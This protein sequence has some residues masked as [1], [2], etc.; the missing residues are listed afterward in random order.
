MS[1]YFPD[2]PFDAYE[3]ERCYHRDCNGYSPDPPR[4]QVRA[5]APDY[6]PSYP[7]FE[8]ATR[9]L[10]ERIR[11]THRIES[12]TIGSLT[13]TERPVMRLVRLPDQ[14]REPESAPIRP[15][16]PPRNAHF[17]PRLA[18]IEARRQIDLALAMYEVD[19]TAYEWR[20]L[21]PYVETARRS[22]KAFERAAKPK[23]PLLRLLDNIRNS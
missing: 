4:E 9:Q 1:Y 17:S 14:K 19:A 3:Y 20:E 16:S 11:P 23:Q 15:K 13:T 18:L 12:L 6:V 10:Q 5:V 7:W 8:E 21:A 22:L 2:P